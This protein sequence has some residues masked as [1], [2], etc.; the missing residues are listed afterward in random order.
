MVDEAGQDRRDDR[1]EIPGY[2]LGTC[3]QRMGWSGCISITHRAE[4]YGGRSQSDEA[5]V[6]RMLVDGIC[7]LVAELVK[8]NI[9]SVYVF[10]CDELPDCSLES[11]V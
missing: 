11:G 10:D 5:T 6:P 2:F 4:G 9:D 7:I 3:E 8:N 1:L